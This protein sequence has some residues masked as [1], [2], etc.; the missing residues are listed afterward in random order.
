MRNRSAYFA[1]TVIIALAALFVARQR[2]LHALRA[3]NDTLRKQVELEK[4]SRGAV[5]PEP[6]AEAATELN[7]RD[8]RELL[9]LR[10]KILPLKEQLR[11]VSNRVVILENPRTGGAPPGPLSPQEAMEAYRQS[12]ATVNACWL[13]MAVGKYVQ[14]NDGKL[15]DDLAT[16]EGRELPVPAGVSQR[17]ELMGTNKVSPEKRAFSLIAREK[18]AQQLP[19]GEWIRTYLV[20]G[21]VVILGP[22][23]KDDWADEESHY[24]KPR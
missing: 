11:D 16:M 23:Q 14:D 13:G 10:S 2:T 7:D 4:S 20:P 15:P 22:L 6:P 3:D 21:G 5:A 9:Q 19:D 12:E 1:L 8:E 17:F 24:G 18:Q